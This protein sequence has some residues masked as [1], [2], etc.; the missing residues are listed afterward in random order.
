MTTDQP[1]RRGGDIHRLLDEAFAGVEV[2]PDLQDLK[3][4]LRDSLLSRQAELE[5]AGVAPGDAARRAFAELGDL[6]EIIGGTDASSPAPA[7]SRTPGSSGQ[8]AQLAMAVQRVRPKPGFVV[9]TVL[10]AI[11][12][13]A[14]LVL[15]VLGLTPVLPLPVGALVG[16]ALGFGIALGLVTGDA[17]RQETTTNHPMPA[18]RAWGY[19]AATGVLLLALALIPVVLLY[20]ELGWIAVPAVAAVAAIGVLSFLGATQTNRHKAWVL[21]Y[22]HEST[23]PNRFE[24]DP[25]S[26][27]RFGIYTAAIWTVAIVATP[28]VG[29]TAGWVWS[30]LPIIAAFVVMLVVLAR[31]LFGDRRDAD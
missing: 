16:L 12:G 5:A 1:A 29:F 28:I 17:L 19:G 8:R 18:A 6:D 26:A 24:E 23:P 31:M 15:L 11:L 25:A 22:H 10:L 20:L 21:R 3:E 9:R 2:T 27:A 7:A 30:P 13:A 14:A 4:E